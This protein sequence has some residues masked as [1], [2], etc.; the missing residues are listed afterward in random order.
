MQK[1]THFYGMFLYLILW[2]ET[3]NCSLVYNIT[4]HARIWIV[5]SRIK[6]YSTKNIKSPAVLDTSQL[7][8]TTILYPSG[9]DN[10]YSDQ[11]NARTI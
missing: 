8:Y 9:L 1:Y 3:E 4:L 2:H 6:A 11:P 7:E 10:I 5:I